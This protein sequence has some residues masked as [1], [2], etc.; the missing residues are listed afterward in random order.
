MMDP[1]KGRK[2]PQ[3]LI[4]VCK[5][6]GTSNKTKAKCPLFNEFPVPLKAWDKPGTNVG[7]AGQRDNGPYGAGSLNGYFFSIWRTLR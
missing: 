2:P 6:S 1:Q 5:I 4:F 7:Q 3:K